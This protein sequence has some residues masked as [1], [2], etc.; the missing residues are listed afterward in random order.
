MSVAKVVEISS[1]S[2]T[3]FEDAI[4]AGIARVAKTVKNIKGAWVSEQKVAVEDG[5]V[6]EF[7]V[8]MRVSFVVA[9]RGRVVTRVCI[10]IH[11]GPPGSARGAVFV[12]TTGTGDPRPPLHRVPQPRPWRRWRTTAG[13]KI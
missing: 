2:K 1:S 10:C 13:R 5:M 6:T 12:L 9:C 3:G 7:R 4:R 11:T 8:T